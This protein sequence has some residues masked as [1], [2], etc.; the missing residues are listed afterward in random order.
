MSLSNK[1]AVNLAFINTPSR[2]LYKLS[3]WV[4]GSWRWFTTLLEKNLRRR[5][6]KQKK[7]QKTGCEVDF[8]IQTLWLAQII[9][10]L[11]QRFELKASSKWKQKHF[12]TSAEWRRRLQFRN[13][14]QSQFKPTKSVFRPARLLPLSIK[15]PSTCHFFLSVFSR[16]VWSAQKSFLEK[17]FVKNSVHQ[18][19]LSNS[20]FSRSEEKKKISRI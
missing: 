1:A 13:C 4:W 8:F 20:H 9:Y 14:V 19:R 10:L 12:L 16:G 17:N 15:N 7:K 2:K 11:H 18:S 5:E 6:T 3:I